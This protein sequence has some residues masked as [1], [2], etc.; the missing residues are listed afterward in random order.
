MSIYF[1]FAFISVLE[2]NCNN[3]VVCHN[4]NERCTKDE[5]CCTHNCRRSLNFFTK[6]CKEPIPIIEL[7][8]LIM[9]PIENSAIQSIGSV[10]KVIFETKE[11]FGLI[12]Q[13]IVFSTKNLFSPAGKLINSSINVIYVM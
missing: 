5:D 2:V 4:L 12:K 7:V 13:S 9:G 11:F 3:S 1:I 8:K 6:Y 10:R